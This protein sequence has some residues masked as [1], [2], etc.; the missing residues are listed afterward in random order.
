[1]GKVHFPKE[2]MEN[3]P[4]ILWYHVIYFFKLYEKSH[5]FLIIFHK[6]LKTK[7]IKVQKFEVSNKLA[8]STE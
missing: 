8:T 1:M 4:L 5:I 2:Q 3:L 6:L 7:N